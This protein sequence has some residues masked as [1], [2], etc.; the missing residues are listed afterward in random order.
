MVSQYSK[1]PE[2]IEE[3]ADFKAGAGKEQDESVVPWCARNC[4]KHE[5]N[6]SK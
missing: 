3:M 2:L 1:E 6:M 5:G 4:S